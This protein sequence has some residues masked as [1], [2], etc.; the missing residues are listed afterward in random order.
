MV[1]RNVEVF[2][3]IRFEEI[4]TYQSLILSACK[5]S[6]TVSFPWESFPKIAKKF[7]NFAT[8]DD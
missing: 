4:A 8:S 5:V 3:C 2:A 7:E 1:V 6:C